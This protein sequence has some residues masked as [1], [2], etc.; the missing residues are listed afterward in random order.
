[1]ERG[2]KQ[3][4]QLV[5]QVS[6]FWLTSWL[7]FYITIYTPVNRPIL[8]TSC[9]PPPFPPEAVIAVASFAWVVL[10]YICMHCVP[11][12]L[13][14]RSF[15][16]GYGRLYLVFW[17]TVSQGDVLLVVLSLDS[18]TARWFGFHAMGPFLRQVRLPS[19]VRLCI[20][21]YLVHRCFGNHQ[22]VPYCCT[23]HSFFLQAPLFAFFKAHLAVFRCVIPGRNSE[24]CPFR[25]F[26]AV[27]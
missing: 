13:V 27:T 2:I 25:L 8:I 17:S 4:L 12:R 24:L 7:T 10:Y 16:H 20:L 9:P 21:L 22:T 26:Q 11:C 14:S 15:C 6:A 1:M 18:A 5:N 3:I 23:Y 19:N